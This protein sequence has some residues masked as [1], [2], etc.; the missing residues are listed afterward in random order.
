MC[1]PE[2]IAC[3]SIHSA[4]S[5]TRVITRTAAMMPSEPKPVKITLRNF[6]P[7]SA[8]R[9]LPPRG[10]GAQAAG[11]REA[12]GDGCVDKEDVVTRAADGQHVLDGAEQL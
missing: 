5:Q 6:P 10:I 9:S 12:I 11:L 3:S 4:D 2:P 7:V 1:A 8:P